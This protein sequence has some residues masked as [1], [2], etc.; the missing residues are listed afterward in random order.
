MTVSKVG[1]VRIRVLAK[2]SISGYKSHVKSAQE[3]GVELRECL[4]GSSKRER[5]GKSGQGA[6]KRDW[7]KVAENTNFQFYGHAHYLQEFEDF[8]LK[9]L[10]GSYAPLYDLERFKVAQEGIFRL[11]LQIREDDVSWDG[12]TPRLE[13]Y[14]LEKILKGRLG[15]K[16]YKLEE[17]LLD[18]ID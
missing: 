16:A 17:F 12:N 11:N 15:S 1:P 4:V 10:E 18:Y 7:S 3:M 6:N 14:N 5:A 9:A 8:V 2:I 13:D